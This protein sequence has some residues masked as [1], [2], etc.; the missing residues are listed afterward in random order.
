M[1]A[2]GIKLNRFSLMGAVAA[3]AAVIGLSAAPARSQNLIQIDGSSTV[4]PISEAMAEEFQAANPDVRVTVGVSGTGGGFKKFC[5]GETVI[6]DASRP[7]KD[8]EKEACA[9]NGIEYIEIPVAY[10]ALTV[11]IN[12]ENTFAAEMTTEELQRLW[13]PDSKIKFWGQL[14]RGWPFQRI[15]LYGPGTDSGTFDYFTKKIVGEEGASRDDYTASEDDNVL[16]LGVQRDPFALGYFG[17][18]YYAENTDSLQAVTINGV[19]PSSATVLNNTYKPLSRP[20]FIYVSTAA[21][22]ERPE[23]KSFVEFYLD[24]APEIVPEVGYVPLPDTDYDELIGKL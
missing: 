9:A 10:D 5:A 18:S 12:P 22:A 11:V 24:R 13:E 4:F 8:I 3:A 19:A 16:V 14:R 23:V 2:N 1:I 15:S 6:S 17:Y 20:I 7:I 21:I